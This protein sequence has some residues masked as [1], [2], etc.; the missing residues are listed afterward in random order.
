[1]LKLCVQRSLDMS[2]L[3]R[4]TP[5]NT[6]YLFIKLRFGSGVAVFLRDGTTGLHVGQ[7]GI[8]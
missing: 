2:H 6:A 1:M 7:L 4:D 5:E 3:L 8:V